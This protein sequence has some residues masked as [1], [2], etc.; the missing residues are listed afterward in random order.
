MVVASS[1]TGDYYYKLLEPRT[2]EEPSTEGSRITNAG[3]R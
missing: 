1:T 2:Q 3:W